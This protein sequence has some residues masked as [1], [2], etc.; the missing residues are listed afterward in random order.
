ME[1][2]RIRKEPAK[3]IF[4]NQLSVA[5]KLVINFQRKILH[6]RQFVNQQRIINTEV[7]LQIVAQFQIGVAFPLVQGQRLAEGEV[8][9]CIAEF[10][11]HLMILHVAGD[12]GTFA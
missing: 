8:G 6:V 4:R 3:F 1:R 10:E 12:I 11:I 2:L 7:Y 5:H 9:A